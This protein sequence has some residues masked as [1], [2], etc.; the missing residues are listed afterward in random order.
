MPVI[1]RVQIIQSAVEY[2]KRL[3]MQQE[4]GR[5]CLLFC[6]ENELLVVFIRYIVM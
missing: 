5:N 6:Y 4:E 3:N 2:A 1:Q